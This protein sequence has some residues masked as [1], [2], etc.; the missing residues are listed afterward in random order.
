MIDLLCC[1]CIEVTFS[2][3]TSI[4]KVFCDIILYVIICLE[5]LLKLQLDEA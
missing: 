4:D 5:K 3:Y 1:V 2:S